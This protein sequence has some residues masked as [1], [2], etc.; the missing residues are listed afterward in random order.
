MLEKVAK[1]E[2]AGVAI[3]QLNLDRYP[4]IGPLYEVTTLPDTRV[5]VGEEV[6]SRFV[7][8]REEVY[9][10]ALIEKG[11][12][13]LATNLRPNSTEIAA[14]VAPSPIPAAPAIQ[15]LNGRQPLPS[16]I[17]AMPAP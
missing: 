16:G 17:E 9:I 2:I 7:G 3:G 11:M 4:A 15:R 12:M 10:E 14:E 6:T 8:V 5:Y 13:T 1:K